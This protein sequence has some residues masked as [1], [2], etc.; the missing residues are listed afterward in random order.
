MTI[1]SISS[2]PVRLS[3]S[4]RATAAGMV[5]DPRMAIGIS[6]TVVHIDRMRLHRIHQDGRQ[7]RQ[8]SVA[9]PRE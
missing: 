1:A 2:R 9:S 7:Q 3:L 8:L 5:T 4:E 6:M